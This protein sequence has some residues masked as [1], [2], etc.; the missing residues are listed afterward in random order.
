MVTMAPMIRPLL[1][2][3]L[4][5]SS[6][7]GAAAILP[8]KLSLTAS[9]AWLLVSL[10]LQLGG[11]VADEGPSS[12]EESVVLSLVPSRWANNLYPP[13]EQLALQIRVNVGAPR[14]EGTVQ[15][16]N[17]VGS[18]PFTRADLR[19][20]RGDDTLV[21]MTLLW[22]GRFTARLTVVN[23]L[24]EACESQPRVQPS[25]LGRGG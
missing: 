14:W 24:V 16:K 13:S 3:I 21:W 10:A 19:G 18:V 6:L 11:G 7:P 25:V 15:L 23:V 9:R 22:A 1:M 12:A 17:T 4:A 20:T 5:S 2:A 8:G